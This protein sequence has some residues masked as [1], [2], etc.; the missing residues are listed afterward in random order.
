MIKIN[1]TII[2][3][4]HPI[5]FIAEIGIN[6]NADLNNV[7][8]LIKAAKL[9]GCN[10]VKF[11]KRNPEECVPKDQ[12]FIQKD[13]P[14]GKMSYIDYKKKMEFTKNEY[15]KII[16]YCKKIQIDWFASCW[17]ISSVKFMNSLNIPCFKIASPSVTDLNLIKEIKKL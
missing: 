8:K 5:Y 6:H 9:A 2:S 3:N 16:S 1:N 12:W 4:N 14:W 15:K 7:Y 13:T 11:Q 17:D 10:A